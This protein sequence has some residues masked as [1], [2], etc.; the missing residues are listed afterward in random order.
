MSCCSSS[1]SH[2]ERFDPAETIEDDLLEETR[3]LNEGAA[4]DP[5]EEGGGPLLFG[6]IVREAE[7]GPS[8]RG[9]PDLMRWAYL[10][11]LVLVMLERGG[12][13]E[14][15]GV[16]L[17]PVVSLRSALLL[18]A[19]TILH[20]VAMKTAEAI[21]RRPTITPGH[22]CLL[23]LLLLPGPGLARLFHA[24]A[25]AVLFLALVYAGSLVNALLR[26]RST[27]DATHIASREALGRGREFLERE[28]LRGIPESWI[29]WAIAFGLGERLGAVGEPFR[30]CGGAG[31]WNELADAL[32]RPVTASAG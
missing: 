29:P 32:V 11:P 5:V 23:P 10:V 14:P 18:A 17:T 25:P 19:A 22:A 16:E 6:H 21:R 24:S 20:F 15:G 27:D 13:Y 2:F 8:Y 28:L 26:A 3:K 1:S 30:A 31:A 4:S 12:D 7:P 9:V